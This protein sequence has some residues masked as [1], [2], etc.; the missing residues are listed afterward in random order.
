[1]KTIIQNRTISIHAI[2]K[3][4]ASKIYECRDIPELKGTR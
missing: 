2:D 3:G 4:V 1:M